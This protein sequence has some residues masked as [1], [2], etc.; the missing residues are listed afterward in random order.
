MPEYDPPKQHGLPSSRNLALGRSVETLLVSRLYP[1]SYQFSSS[2]CDIFCQLQVILDRF[3][4]LDGTVLP[5]LQKQKEHEED[6]EPG[7]YT[8]T[9]SNLGESVLISFPRD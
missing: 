9:I 5:F 2:V 3:Q 7:Q 1:D 6:W 4:H 8:T